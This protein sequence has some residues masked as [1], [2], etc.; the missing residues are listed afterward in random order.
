MRSRAAMRRVRLRN[1]RCAAMR[2]VQPRTDCVQL[3][4]GVRA[5]AGVR[6]P[7]GRERGR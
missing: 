5:T 1:G 7:D 6:V 3:L 2:R 4:I